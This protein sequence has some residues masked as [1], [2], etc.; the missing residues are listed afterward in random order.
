MNL[1]YLTQ[2][3]G[4]WQYERR[5]PKAVLSHPYWGE[6]KSWK[7]PLGL[8]IGAPVEDVLSAWKERHHIFETSL[9]NIKDR[10]PHILDKRERRR[11]AEAH[12]KMFNLK[13]HDGSLESINDDN[14]RSHHADY[15]DNVRELFGAFDDYVH[16][17][18]T[19]QM[20]AREDGSGLKPPVNMMPPEVQL[21]RGRGSLTPKTN[22]S[23]H[24]LCSVT[25][26]TSTPQ[27]RTLT[28]TIGKTRK[29][30]AGGNHLWIS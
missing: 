30:S 15:I 2:N 9:A 3:N 16:W 4:Y 18:Q 29:R 21:Q 13:P 1:K 11:R 17:E 5:V 7:R 26:G 27:A 24:P 14:E 20:K 12:L 23:K 19:H 10:N 22:P 25:S 28:S 8:K 6:K